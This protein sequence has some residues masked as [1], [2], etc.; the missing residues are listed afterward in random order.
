MSWITLY[1][2]LDE[3]DKKLKKYLN[4]QDQIETRATFTP[5]KEPS[6]AFVSDSILLIQYDLPLSSTEK[7]EQ[8]ED[9]HLLTI[10]DATIPKAQRTKRKNP[11]SQGGAHR[12]EG[13]RRGK[14]AGRRRTPREGKGRRWRRGCRQEGGGEGNTKGGQGHERPPTDNRHARTPRRGCGHAYYFSILDGHAFH[15]GKGM[16]P[17]G[18]HRTPTSKLEPIIREIQRR[19]MGS[20]LQNSTTHLERAEEFPASAHAAALKPSENLDNSVKAIGYDFNKGVDYEGI[21]HSMITT[22]FQ[23]SHLGQA[24]ALVNNMLDWRLLDEPIAEDCS[25]EERN[26]SFRES[27][28]CCCEF[29]LLAQVTELRFMVAEKCVQVNV[30]VTTA[31]GVEEDLIK[32]LAP[33]YTGDFSLA[34]AQLR[35]KGLNRIGNLLVPNDNYCMFEDWIIPIFDQLLK[36]QKEQTKPIC[37]T[38]PEWS[39]QE[40]CIKQQE[41][42]LRMNCKEK[43]L[44]KEE[45]SYMK[46][47]LEGQGLEKKKTT[48]ER[49]N[50]KVHFGEGRQFKQPQRLLQV[51]IGPYVWPL[52]PERGENEF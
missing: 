9:S 45:Q 39:G 33:T 48:L 29:A 11:P 10:E 2:S 12:R 50:T 6:E 35:S 5:R 40:P 13:G 42:H 32:C 4:K 37:W 30:V 25:E 14:G 17:Y 18:A 22:G 20:E 31:G 28:K 43:H 51:R 15:V 21:L 3:R 49:R 52:G 27:V 41:E 47:I 34:G 7:V 44:A 19:K 26:L 16:A 8:E 46:G 36:E 23:A 24:I 1:S 38:T